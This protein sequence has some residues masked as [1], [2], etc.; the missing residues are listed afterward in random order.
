MFPHSIPKQQISNKS[1]HFSII[2]CS[3][4][5]LGLVSVPATSPVNSSLLTPSL[6]NCPCLNKSHLAPEVTVTPL[7]AASS[8]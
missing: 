6:R 1:S 8:H 3:R 7:W 4:F 5:V 2:H